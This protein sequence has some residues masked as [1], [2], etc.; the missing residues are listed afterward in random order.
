MDKEDLLR[1]LLELAQRGV[2]GEAENAKRMAEEIAKKYNVDLNDYRRLAIPKLNSAKKDLAVVA[3]QMCGCVLYK[4]GYNDFILGKH[5][6]LAWDCYQ[7][8]C[9]LIPKEDRKN[10]AFIHSFADTLMKRLQSEPGWVD[11]KK[12]IDTIRKAM[13]IPTAKTRSVKGSSRG[14]EY[15]ES[16]SLRRQTDNTTKYIARK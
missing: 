9:G 7:Y 15:G 10:S 13:E 3:A 5:C 1:K 16:V 8:L 11:T 2:G 4:S 6:E 14:A 12:E